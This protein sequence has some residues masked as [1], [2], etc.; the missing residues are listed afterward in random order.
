MLEVVIGDGGYLEWSWEAC[1]LEHGKNKMELYHIQRIK[2]MS[3]KCSFLR[4]HLFVC[5]LSGGMWCGMRV[6]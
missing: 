1:F 4:L 5:L 6:E 3:E 2:S